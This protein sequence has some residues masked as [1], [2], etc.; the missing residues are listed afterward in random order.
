[1]IVHFDAPSQ[2][3]LK[4]HWPYRWPKSVEAR[5]RSA[6]GRTILCRRSTVHDEIGAGEIL[7]NHRKYA[8][9]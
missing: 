7:S 5:E 4:F 1:M 6:F 9:H 8:W 3:K 2:D